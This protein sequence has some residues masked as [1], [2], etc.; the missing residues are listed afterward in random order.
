MTKKQKNKTKKMSNTDTTKKPGV[1]PGV[2]E[3]Q[4]LPV[5][6]FLH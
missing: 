6:T 3:G 4:V 2:P 1:N 5:S